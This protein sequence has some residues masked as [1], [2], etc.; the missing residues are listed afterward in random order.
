MPTP[1]VAEPAFATRRSTV[2]AAP[3]QRDVPLSSG[4]LGRV[5]TGLRRDERPSA[6][7][8]AGGDRRRTAAALDQPAGARDVDGKDAG[9]AV[10]RQLRKQVEVGREMRPLLVGPATGSSACRRRVVRVVVAVQPLQSRRRHDGSVS[11]SSG[12]PEAT[13]LPPAAFTR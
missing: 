4:A 12:V 8:V 7:V 13:A 2:A 10:E 11:T 3:A 9:D 1:S 5:A 6:A